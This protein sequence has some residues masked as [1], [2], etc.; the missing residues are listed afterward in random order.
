MP[1]AADFVWFVYIICIQSTLFANKSFKTP[2]GAGIDTWHQDDPS[3]YLVT[4][5]EPPKNVRL[6]FTANKL[7]QYNLCTAGSVILFNN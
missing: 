6:P 3:R 2:P 5:G 1:C 7:V 4:K